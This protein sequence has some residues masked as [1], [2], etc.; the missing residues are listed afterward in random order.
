VDREARIFEV[1]PPEALRTGRTR[2]NCTA[3]SSEQGRFYWFSQ[4]WIV[5][6]D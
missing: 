4:Q 3:P 6:P 2:Y 1:E 5:L